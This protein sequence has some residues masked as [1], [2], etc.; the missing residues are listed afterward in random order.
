M[1]GLQFEGTAGEAQG[2]ILKKAR[3][4]YLAKYQTAEKIPIEQLEDPTFKATYYVIKPK[5]NVLFDEI[6]FP[7]N[8]RQE[9]KL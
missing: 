3:E 8:P 4:L 2:A 9:L 6:N 1:R 7:D 5:L